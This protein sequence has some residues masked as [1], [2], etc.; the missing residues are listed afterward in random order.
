LKPHLSDDQLIDLLYGVEQVTPH[1]AECEACTARFEAFEQRHRESIPTVPVTGEFLA[2]QR[3][4]IHAR[5]DQRPVTRLKWVPALV[6]A[7][8]LFVMVLVHRPTPA[9]VTHT[10]SGDA[11]LFS[12]VYS[13]EQSSVEP[14]AA[15]PIHE[16][17]EDNQ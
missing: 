8:L 6:A 14:A 3:R 4:Q 7:C 17:F 11:Q 10:D 12:E 2:A 5:L 15:A 1:L 13:M 16:L 9:P